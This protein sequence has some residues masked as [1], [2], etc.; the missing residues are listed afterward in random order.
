MAKNT[1]ATR[2]KPTDSL[3]NKPE[4]LPGIFS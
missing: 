3:R 1:I 4:M 2:L